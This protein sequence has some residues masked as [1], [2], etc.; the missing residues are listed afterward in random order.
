VG[1]AAGYLDPLTGEGI[2]LG[3]RSAQAL[4]ETLAAGRPLAAYERRYRRLSR[5]FYLLTGTLLAA[6][7]IAPLRRRLVPCLAAHAEVFER[8]V[9]INAGQRPIRSVG[10]AGVWQLVAGLATAGT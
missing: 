9:Q 1:D 6:T 7:R 4:V 8:L 3:L 5:D 2:T 10:L